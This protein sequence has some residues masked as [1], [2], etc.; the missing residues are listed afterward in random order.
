MAI[1]HS[2]PITPALRLIRGE[3]KVTNWHIAPS[4]CVTTHLAPGNSTVTGKKPQ[5]TALA[6]LAQ[7]QLWPRDL[8]RAVERQPLGDDHCI[9]GINFL[10]KA[11]P[12]YWSKLETWPNEIN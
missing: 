3:A 10:V 6:G 7:P 2:L 4:I 11:L 8:L 5:N 12:F 1:P 9:R